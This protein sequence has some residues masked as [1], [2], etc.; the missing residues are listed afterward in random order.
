MEETLYDGQGH[1]IAYIAHD[2]DMAI[3]LWS[4][5]A[6]AYVDD[7]NLYGWNGHHIGWL[8]NGV[9]YNR[10]GQRTG[11][12]GSQ[13]RFALHATPAKFAKFAQFA[14]FARHAAFARPALSTSY[15]QQP[16]VELLKSGAV[17]NV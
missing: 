8:I 4:G 14:K 6:V 13:C 10:Q 16:L 17:G 1:P 7:E 5:H 15:G 11:S 9:V 2:R 12:I 3:Y